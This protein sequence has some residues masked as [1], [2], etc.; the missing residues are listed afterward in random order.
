MLLALSIGELKLFSRT[1]GIYMQAL[2]DETPSKVI[3]LLGV[4]LASLAF[5]F[6]VSATDAGFEGTLSQVPDPFSPARVVAVI[7]NAA[8]SYSVFLATNLIQPAKADYT[9]VADSVSWTASNAKDG[10]LAMIG[11]KPAAPE[12]PAPLANRG[13]GRVAGASTEIKSSAQR[14]AV[15]PGLLDVLYSVLIQ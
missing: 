14:E 2:V 4:A 10:A 12:I 6:I 5:L 11:A 15:R 1:K 7:D 8:S 9:V 13:T 3:S